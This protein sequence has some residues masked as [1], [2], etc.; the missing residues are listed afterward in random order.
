MVSE[1]SLD[2]ILPHLGQKKSL[3]LQF[4]SILTVF[5]PIHESNVIP[6]SILRP[7]FEFSHQDGPVRPP[8]R[9]GIENVFL[10]SHSI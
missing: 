2:S 4:R 5:R 7:Y 3:K 9:K 6:N 8:I 10:A 1:L